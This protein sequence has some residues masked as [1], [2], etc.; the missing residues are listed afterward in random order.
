MLPAAIVLPLIAFPM[1][2]ALVGCG[3]AADIELAEESAALNVAPVALVPMVDAARLACAAEI[4]TTYCSEA[5][6]VRAQ[7]ACDARLDEKERAGCDG[8]CLALFSPDRS[9]CRSGP[10]YPSRRACQTPKVDDCAFYRACMEP[11]TPCG[12]DGYA[13]GFGERL[14]N[15]FIARRDRFSPAGQEWLRSIRK[16]LQDDRVGDL[17]AQLSCDALADRSYDSHA[18][19]YTLPEHS[20]CDLSSHD[21]AVLLEL[22]GK[23]LFSS[24][25][26]KQIFDVAGACLTR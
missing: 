5:T 22:V 16:C 13:L 20:I 8:P 10:T 25:G 2:I 9:D 21:R 18:R 14:C 26:L 24:R 12:E 19:C 11:T 6:A 23:D 1:S 17:D 4:T 15:V 7:E 3:Q